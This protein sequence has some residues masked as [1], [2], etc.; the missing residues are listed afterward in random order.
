LIIADLIRRSF[1][2]YGAQ[3][4]VKH[5]ERTQT[6]AQ[7]C[8]RSVRLVNGLRALRV[9]P[10][11][12]VATLGPNSLT[13]LEVMTGL[14]LGGYVRAALHGMNAADAHAY[15]LGNAGAKALITTVEMY[16][17]FS[18]TFADVPGLEHVIVQDAPDG[19]LDYESLL[20]GADSDD[21]RV[22]VTGDSLLHL[23]YSSGSSGRPKASMHS[24]QSWMNVT[25]DHAL[26]LPRLTSEDT[27]LAAAPLT[28]AA[29]TIIYALLARGSRVLVM[30]HFDAALALELIERE[31]CTVT[32]MVPTMLQLMVNDD[33][34][35]RR[36]LSSLRAVLY[37]GAPISPATARRS[38]DLLG[39]V[40]FQTYG[41]S[42]CLPA[43]CLTPED[44]AEG[45]STNAT[46]LRSAGRPCLNASV[47]ILDDDGN[48]V[49]GS[50]IG[51]I[52]VRSHG[53]MLGIYGD[54]AATS[55]RLTSD[56]Y[57]RTRDSGYLDEHGYVYVVDRKDD[58]IIS[59]GFNI[60]PA[61][62]ENAL[63]QHAAVEDVVVVAVP[64]AKWG[65]TP[66]AVVRL[67]PHTAASE[68][69]LI[70]FC[71][72]RLGSMKKPTAIA[73]TL[74]PF[75]RSDLGKLQRR[76]IR[77]QFWPSERVDARNIAG[78]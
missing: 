4:A 18:A 70:E 60:W 46:L 39:D 76:E 74:D 26:M 51:E 71:R 33:A 27:Y 9:Q 23:A 44:H 64:H 40:L 7:L 67:R 32:V 56:G 2:Q 41:Q 10:G 52:A 34:A 15:M 30:D 12:R 45:A 66:H 16:R 62:I 37:A 58:M 65:E 68:Q 1:S 28:H 3:V 47:R 14:A 75:P 21:A 42:E 22:P 55:A 25:T 73:F 61:E 11:D 48:D 59:G 6:Y 49:S 77:D 5:G 29:S 43:T 8:D 20:A 53:R 17:Q 72:D 50:E 69:E 78:P 63:G 19:V 54:A 13:T 31:R 57:V 35:G 38:R 24:H 36:D